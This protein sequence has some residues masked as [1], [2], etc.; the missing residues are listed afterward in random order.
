LFRPTVNVYAAAGDAVRVCNARTVKDYRSRGL[1]VLESI[2]DIYLFGL[3]IGLSALLIAPLARV[4][5]AEDALTKFLIKRERA[6]RKPQPARPQLALARMRGRKPRADRQPARPNRRKQ[7]AAA[8]AK[9]IA[10]RRA[11]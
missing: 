5:G 6:L 7:P 10:K 2:S 1:A 8:V 9:K 11:T 3:C 4:E